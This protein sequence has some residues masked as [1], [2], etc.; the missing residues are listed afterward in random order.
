[1]VNSMGLLPEIA[2]AAFPPHYGMECENCEFQYLCEDHLTRDIGCSK[3]MC[4]TRA[5][6]TQIDNAR[7]ML[8]KEPR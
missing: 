5:T 3:S 7:T 4:K 6:C 8:G 1:M 2:K